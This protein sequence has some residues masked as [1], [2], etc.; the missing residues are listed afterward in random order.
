MQKLRPRT[1]DDYWRVIESDVIPRLGDRKVDSVK[2][3]DMDH[4][5]RLITER[6]S[7]IAA[8]MCMS[9]CRKLFSFAIQH[10]M[11]SSNPAKGIERNG[12]Q[13]RNRYMSKVEI[14]SLITALNAYEDQ[15]V[16]DLFRLLL[17]TGARRGE[18]Q[19]AAWDQFNLSEGIW[20]KPSAHTKQKREH[21]VPLA[22]PAL[23]LLAK[24]RAQ[25][26]AEVKRL[27]REIDKAKG[28][29]RAALQEGRRRVETWVF[30]SRE[31]S[32]G[33]LVEVKKAWSALCKQAGIVE[34][35]GGKT[36]HNARIHDLRHTAASVLASSGASLPLIGQLLGH[37]QPTTTARY[38]H[39]FDDAQRAAV[40]RLGAVISGGPSA[41]IIPLAGARK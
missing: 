39:L 31:S 9:I 6:G 21:R 23:A 30:P 40:E 38:A 14:A 8:N 5:H 27:D 12:A 19:A 26:D 24:R 25:A 20:V 15:D 28:A 36:R 10:E 34:T 32:T 2:F 11:T 33:H 4:L 22:A 1:R 16:A 18:T 13:P 29:E 35:A 37:T 41:E 7:P 3:A 17:L